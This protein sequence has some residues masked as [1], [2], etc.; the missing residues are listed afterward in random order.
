M[1]KHKE[2]RHQRWSPKMMNEQTVLL[3]PLLGEQFHHRNE[4]LLNLRMGQPRPL[5]HLFSS[6]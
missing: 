2:E 6:F 3:E 4:N 5:F 1:M